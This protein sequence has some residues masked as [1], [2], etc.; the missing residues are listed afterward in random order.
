[1]ADFLF[2]GQNAIVILFVM[3]FLVGII[4]GSF[5]NVLIFRIPLK[6]DIAVERS[7]CM[8]CGHVLSWY[9]LIPLVS[10]IIQGGKCRACK[11]K[12][13]AQYPIVEA[14]NAILWIGVVL[15]W[16]LR[17]ET[18]LFCIC[19]SILIVLSV[20]D[21]RTQEIP[22]G[23]NIAIAVLGVAR[24]I[25]VLTGKATASGPWYEYVI[26]AFVV[27]GLFLLIVVI[28]KGRGMGGGDVKLMAAAGLLL[29]WKHILLAMMLGCILGSVIHMLRMLLDKKKK[30][31][32]VLAFG[33]YLAIG[34]YL[35]I[36]F[37]NPIIAWYSHFFTKV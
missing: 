37:G 20:I 23:L 17:W 36:L 26:G 5:L 4:V 18:L 19:S 25:L 28:T 6:E 24:L 11:A 1:M 30:K 10:W 8:H 21:E 9:E 14:L 35:T 33:P 32:H 34:I 3:L 2:I 29:G 13:S 7:H 27:S 12:I 15:V 22:I 31:E 16:G